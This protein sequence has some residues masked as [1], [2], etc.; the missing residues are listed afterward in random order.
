MTLTA[1]QLSIIQSEL[2]ND[3]QTL[4]YSGKSAADIAALM[5]APGS[6]SEANRVEIVNP[7]PVLKLASEVMAL[8]ISID[9]DVAPLLPDCVGIVEVLHWIRTSNDERQ[10]LYDYFWQAGAVLDLT[11]PEVRNAIDYLRGIEMPQNKYLIS[12]DCMNTL[13]ALGMVMNMRSNEL[14]NRLITESE[15]AAAVAA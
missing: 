6:A 10:P 13:L 12:E 3:P 4:G 1:N 7:T 15:V 14:I 2:T 5:N 9:G 8:A 11:K